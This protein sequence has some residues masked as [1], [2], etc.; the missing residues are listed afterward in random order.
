[1]EKMKM[2]LEEV[3]K[4]KCELM[5]MIA[6]EI[7]CGKESLAAHIEPFGELVDAAKDL[8]EIE[9]KCAKAK[10]Y[11]TVVEA[12]EESKE[13]SRE[14]HHGS[15]GY[16]NWRYA[17]GR[18][19]PTGKGHRSG[20]RPD[21][22]MHMGDPEFLNAWRMG[23]DDDMRPMDEKGSKYRQWDDAR[24]YYHET[25]SPEAKGEMDHKMEENVTE[26][27]SQLREM[28]Q[29]SSPEMQK[30]LKM[31]VSKLMDEMGRTV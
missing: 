26:V 9:E 23:Y 21:P 16:D 8:A 6:S 2:D 5:H 29:E 18:F 15:Y 22:F 31:K 19:A 14:P 30:E 7:S 12:M 25:G 17:S 1:M 20:Y 11:E 3:R 27:L 28:H 10:Y 24:R 13:E 4:S